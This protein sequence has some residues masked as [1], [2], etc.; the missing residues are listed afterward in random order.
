MMQIR[1]ANLQ[2]LQLQYSRAVMEQIQQVPLQVPP[3]SK[4]QG[5]S[6]FLGF[7]IFIVGHKR[8]GL[9]GRETLNHRILRQGPY[10]GGGMHPGGGAG[11]S[12]PLGGDA[13]SR[14]VRRASYD[15]WDATSMLGRGV[16]VGGGGIFRGGGEVQH[17]FM[18]VPSGEGGRGGGERG[19]QREGG[20]PPP[21]VVGVGPLQVRFDSDRFDLISPLDSMTWCDAVWRRF[22]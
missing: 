17:D 1:Q 3:T 9:Y 13:T 21:G 19:R 2:A 8:F 7:R 15:G 6:G 16:G 4:F 12:A 22:A 5:F 18:R 10:Q 14:W 20:H 11:L